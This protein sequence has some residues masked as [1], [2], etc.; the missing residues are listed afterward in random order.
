M[1]DP[2]IGLPRTRRIKRGGD[3]ARIKQEGHRVVHGCLIL[4]WSRREENQESRLGV[5]TSRR[6]GNAV[7]RNRARRLLREAFRQHH[8][9]LH[10]VVDLVLIARNSIVGRDYAGVE[11]DYL[12]ALRRAKL[13]SR[14]PGPTI[15]TTMPRVSSNPP[16]GVPTDSHP[17]PSCSS[18]PSITPTS[19]S[20]LSPT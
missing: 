17:A 4:N 18:T 10:P 19:S 12:E 8:K 16:S 14:A 9:I 3:F 1:A 20:T 5:V 7:I 11:K 2:F 15:G 13:L 6:I